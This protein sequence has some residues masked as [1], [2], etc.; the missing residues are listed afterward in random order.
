M[1]TNKNT[2]SKNICKSASSQL[3]KITNPLIY[4][5]YEKYITTITNK[6]KTSQNILLNNLFRRC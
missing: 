4:K 6:F 1:L 2:T 3:E 5:Q